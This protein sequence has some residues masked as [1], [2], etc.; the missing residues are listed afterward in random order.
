[1]NAHFLSKLTGD[2]KKLLELNGVSED[3]IR[4]MWIL[5]VVDGESEG[6]I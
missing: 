4:F 6:N 3:G 1:M 2:S 5:T